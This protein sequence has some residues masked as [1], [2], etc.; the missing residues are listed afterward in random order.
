MTFGRSARVVAALGCAILTSTAACTTDSGS[1]GGASGA[2]GAAGNPSGDIPIGVIADMTGAAGLFGPPTKN[3]AELA[4]EQINAGGGV[5]GRKV[6]LTFSD[7]G[8]DPSIARENAQRLVQQQRVVALFGMFS[9]AASAAVLPVAK[10][11]DVP[12]FYTP[13]WQGGICDANLFANGEVPSQQLGPVIPFVQ[14]QTGRKSWYLLGND[15]IWP[16]ESFR[17]A[18]QYIAAAGGTVVGEDYVPLGTTDFSSQINAIRSSSGA[19]VMIPALVGADAIAFEKQAHDAGLGNRQVQRLA[20]LYEDNTRAAMGPDVTDGMFVSTGYDQ[21]VDTPE[22]KRF[23]ADYAAKFG[24][25]APPVTTLS[26]Q[27]YVAVKAWAKAADTA[28]DTAIAGVGKA[29]SGLELQAPA[30]TVTF[31]ANHYT[32]Q[33]IYVIK[34]EGGAATIVQTYRST[35]P[36]QNCSF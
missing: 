23:L 26:Q 12:F 33:P 25:S 36:R 9:S 18:K 19:D 2:S 22:N 7:G 4:V 8:T 34:I 28:R 13:V 35:D 14:Q 31:G 11:G 6:V 20:I 17:Q 3:V 24:P 16:R 27:T 15:Y 1:S 30:G 21:A 29:L 32:T 10:R 5:N